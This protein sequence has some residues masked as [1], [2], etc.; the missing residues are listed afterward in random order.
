MTGD[1][2]RSYMRNLIQ[3]Q[4][5]Q[6]KLELRQQQAKQLEIE[7]QADTKASK[8]AVAVI[9]WESSPNTATF[10]HQTKE[11][12]ADAGAVGDVEPESTAPDER[13]SQLHIFIWR[14]DQALK[15]QKKPT[16]QQLWNE[17][18]HRHKIHDTNRI[19]QG[20]DGQQILW[21]SG[22]GNEQKLQRTTFDKTLSNIR[23]N[24]P[25]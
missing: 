25:L 17:I 10:N 2:L 20:V 1:I 4:K 5:A 19:I 8:E 6:E 23:K 18:Q 15:Q 21:C 13:Q 22:Y 3:E 9:E 16:A 24:P 14:V 11:P 7:H 12:L